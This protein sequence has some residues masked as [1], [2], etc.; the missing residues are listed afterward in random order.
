[1]NVV[2]N[3]VPA[4]D[5]QQCSQLVFAVR[6][7]DIGHGESHHH[8]VRMPRRLLIHRINQ[9]KGVFRVVPL[10]GLRFDPD[11]KEFRPKI[12]PARLFE[13]DM[14]NVVRIRR[15]DVEALIEK[16]LRRIGVRVDYDGGIV[17]GPGFRADR[18]SASVEGFAGVCAQARE[19]IRTKIE[20]NL[21]VIV[22]LTQSF[23][24]RGVAGRLYRE[25]RSAHNVNP[26]SAKSASAELT[27]TSNARPV[28]S[29][30]WRK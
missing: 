3:R 23:A 5:S 1:M 2:F 14:P 24:Q 12:S 26:D 15:A 10:I 17:D 9:I 20:R 22:Y 27:Q 18:S 13:A 16:S 6:P 11:R 28:G 8:P 19:E 4:L 29:Q 21:F 30:S 7:L 25:K